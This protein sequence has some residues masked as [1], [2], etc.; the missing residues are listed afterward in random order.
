MPA[1]S[2]P[3]SCRNCRRRDGCARPGR[4]DGHGIAAWHHVRKIHFTVPDDATAG[5]INASLG[6]RV[7]VHYE[8]HKWIPSSCFWRHRLFRHSSAGDGVMGKRKRPRKSH[9]NGRRDRVLRADVG[10]RRRSC[11][12]T[13]RARAKRSATGCRQCGGQGLLHHALPGR[14]AARGPNSSPAT[15]PDRASSS[16]ANA[17]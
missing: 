14:G 7:S 6:K 8:Q 2:G 10:L 9:S 15:S 17:F 12:A 5:R 13:G 4:G 1:A 11:C 16:K 3:V